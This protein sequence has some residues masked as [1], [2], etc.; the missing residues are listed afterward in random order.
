[1]T[2]RYIL[3]VGWLASAACGSDTGKSGPEGSIPF[4]I[5][6]LLKQPLP[7]FLW[8]TRDAD[9]VLAELVELYEGR[10]F[11]P[12]WVHDEG[13]SPKGDAVRDV[14]RRAPEHGLRTRDYLVEVLAA[15]NYPADV[16]AVDNEVKSEIELSLSFATMQFIKDLDEGRFHPS[17]LKVGDDLGHETRDLSLELTKVER[18]DSVEIAMDGYAPPFAGYHRLREALVRYR[19]IAMNDPWHALASDETLHPG[20]R[21][22]DIERL[23]ERLR[24]TGDLRAGASSEGP[25]YEGALVDAMKRFQTRRSLNAEGVVGEH[26]FADLNTPWSNRVAQIAASMER[27]RWLPHDVEG[28]PILANVPEFRLH[29]GSPRGSVYEIE[30][31]SRIIVG[32]AYNRLRTPLFSGKLSYVEFRPYWNV[33]L[34]IVQN[35]M[36]QQLD[37]PGYLADHGYEIV[38]GTALDATPLAVTADAIDGVR[39]GRLQ[40]RQRPGRGNALGLVKFI[41]PNEHSVFLHSTPGTHLFQREERAFSHGCIR[42]ADALGLAEWVLRGQAN[43]DR[44]AIETAMA[45]GPTVRV[46][47]ERDIPVYIMYLTAYVNPGSG[48]VHFGHDVYGLD[49]QLAHALGYELDGLDGLN[50]LNGLAIQSGDERLR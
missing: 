14:L 46:P 29:A 34:S 27:V 33:P 50:G 6:S 11:E 36:S 13:M 7:D 39:T 45:S 4:H 26:T 25:I 21:Y 37:E 38:E 10:D 2:S 47:V 9:R 44:E 31:Q 1:M 32:Q 48:D 19:V 35:E 23:R 8:E 43:W 41:F 12:M 3:I 49:A 42:V 5:Q 24:F 20:D 30:F 40:L 22:T 18:S 16:N 17:E 28:T 15:E